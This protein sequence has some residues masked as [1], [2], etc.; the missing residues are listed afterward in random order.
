M[1]YGTIFYVDKT[2]LFIK[3]RPIE[4]WKKHRQDWKEQQNLNCVKDNQWEG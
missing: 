4:L 3:L 1:A 2:P